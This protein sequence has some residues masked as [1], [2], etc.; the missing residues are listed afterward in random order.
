MHVNRVS[1]FK[2]FYVLSPEQAPFLPPGAWAEQ[3]HFNISAVMIPSRLAEGLSH[4]I[5]THSLFR[6]PDLL[7]LLLTGYQHYKGS[8]VSTSLQVAVPPACPPASGS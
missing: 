6:H 2:N 3:I 5:H 1:A 8:Q 4:L 7:L